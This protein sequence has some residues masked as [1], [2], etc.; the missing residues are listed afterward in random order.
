MERVFDILGSQ[1]FGQDDDQVLAILDIGSTMTSLS[2]LQNSRTIYTREQVFGGAQLTEE[3]QRR[4]GLSY[5]EAGMAKKQ[6]GLPDD[7]VPEVLEPFKEGIVQQVS[8]ALQFFYS[9]S[10]YGEVDHLVLA[11]G[12]AGIEGIDEMIEER[13]GTTASIANPFTDMS[14]SSKVNAQ[15]LSTDAPALMISC[16]LALRSFD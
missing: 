9:S 13:L 12:C 16:G 4:Y 10:Q 1:I 11:G 7:Y 15:A 3:I 5:E 14:L 6:G 8:R 2:V